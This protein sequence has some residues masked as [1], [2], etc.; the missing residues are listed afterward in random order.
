MIFRAIKNILEYA[1]F[2]QRSYCFIQN[3][4]HDKNCKWNSK[5]FQTWENVYL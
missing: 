2:P 5:F 3:L 4:S 1:F